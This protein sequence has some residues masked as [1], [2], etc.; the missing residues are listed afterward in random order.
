MAITNFVPV[1]VMLN[2]IHPFVM[3]GM[4]KLRSQL[5]MGKRASYI[6]LHKGH[7]C[8]LKSYVYI[9]ILLLLILSNLANVNRYIFSMFPLL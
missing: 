2:E 9:N 5:P 3:G 6:F 4:I 1:T 7:I 8:Q